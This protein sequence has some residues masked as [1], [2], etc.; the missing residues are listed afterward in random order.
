MKNE[1]IPIEIINIA[2]D[3]YAVVLTDQAIE[4][5]VLPDLIEKLGKYHAICAEGKLAKIS[6]KD[7]ETYKADVAAYQGEKG[8][9]NQPL[10]ITVGVVSIPQTLFDTNHYLL[11]GDPW[12]FL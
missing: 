5:G 7:S 12:A 10:S 9:F 2:S 1:G 4:D 3:Q 8:Y 11:R 6:L